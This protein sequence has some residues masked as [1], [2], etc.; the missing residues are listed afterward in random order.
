[1]TTIAR[2]R[3]APQRGILVQLALALLVGAT[4]GSVL[5]LQLVTPAGT[6]AAA[7]PSAVD[8]S[9]TTAG[10]QYRDWYSPARDLAGSTSASRQ[11]TDWYATHDSRDVPTTA[12]EQ[13]RAWYV[14]ANEVR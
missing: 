2:H 9:T 4:A 7:L 14:D 6:G 5:T 8:V 12:G 10:E 13:Y 3:P 1:M 11:Y